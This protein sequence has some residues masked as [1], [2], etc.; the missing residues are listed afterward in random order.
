MRFYKLK[1]AIKH[2]NKRGEGVIWF[3][4][5]SKTYYVI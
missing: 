2:R 3:D 4:N 5:E 1:D